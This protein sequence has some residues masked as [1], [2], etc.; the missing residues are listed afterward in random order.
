MASA[1]LTMA[2]VSHSA[3]RGA[4]HE[5]IW[6]RWLERYLPTRY[7]VGTGFVIDSKGQQSLQQDIILFDRQYSPLLL[8]KDGILFVPAEAVYAIIEVKSNLGNAELK[9]AAKKIAS[10]KALSRAPAQPV[11]HAGGVFA[12]RARNV[13][14]GYVAA[15][16][17]AWL[18]KTLSRGIATVAKATPEVIDGGCILDR[19]GFS[20]EYVGGS[21]TVRVAPASES[22]FGFMSLL[23]ED[24]K[25]VGTTPPWD[26]GTYSKLTRSLRRSSQK[27]A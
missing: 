1:F 20:I 16:S 6:G 7:S 5:Q 25:A 27:H 4:G 10:V 26:L 23:V 21:P 8:N 24:L 12:A 22:L 17:S 11:I 9:D 13:I 15:S 14:R 3:T 18:T 19:G 2:S